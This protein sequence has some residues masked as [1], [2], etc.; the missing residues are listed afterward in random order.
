MVSNKEIQEQLQREAE[1]HEAQK[2]AEEGA[3]ALQKKLDE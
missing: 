3:E 2:R 1:A